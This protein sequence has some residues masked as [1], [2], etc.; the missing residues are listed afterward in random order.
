MLQMGD[1]YNGEDLD[2]PLE[3]AEWERSGGVGEE[4]WGRRGV[5]E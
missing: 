4:W 2:D 1:G 3:L 5:M